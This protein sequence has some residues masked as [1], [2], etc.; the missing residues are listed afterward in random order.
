MPKES[1]VRIRCRTED[2]YLSRR[3]DRSGRGKERRMPIVSCDL[4][5]CRYNHV[6]TCTAEE[7]YLSADHICDGGCDDGW[8]IEEE[9]EE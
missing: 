4:D 8:D 3:R 5:R 7:I 2:E 9:S 1:E 6:G